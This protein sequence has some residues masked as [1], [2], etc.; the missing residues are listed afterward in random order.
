LAGVAILVLIVATVF[1][2]LYTAAVTESDG[3]V[4]ERSMNLDATA[5]LTAD[6]LFNDALDAGSFCTLVNTTATYKDSDPD[7]E[8]P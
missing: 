5:Q 1:L 6:K 3:A 4:K 2:G 7:G 8:S